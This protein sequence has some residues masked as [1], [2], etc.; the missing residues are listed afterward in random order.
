M[1]DLI[2]HIWFL[3]ISP[4]IIFWLFNRKES[5][6]KNRNDKVFAKCCSLESSILSSFLEVCGTSNIFFLIVCVNAISPFYLPALFFSVHLKGSKDGLCP[7][8]KL[9]A[10]CKKMKSLNELYVI[11]GGDHSL[12][13]A[14]KHL[15]MKGLAQDK[16]EDLAIQA[17]ASFVSRCIGGK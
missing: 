16:A 12:K 2:S 17:V 10:V 14:K 6:K 4:K 15:Q 13:I 8:D 7:L 5:I 1:L 3:F 11:D 9:E